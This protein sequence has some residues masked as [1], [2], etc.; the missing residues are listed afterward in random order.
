MTILSSVRVLG[1]FTDLQEF[2][3]AHSSAAAARELFPRY[4]GP[5]PAFLPPEWL[6]A[7]TEQESSA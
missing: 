6:R 2:V 4:P 3:D 7:L 5:L 1:A